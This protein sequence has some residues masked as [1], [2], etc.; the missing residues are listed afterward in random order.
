MADKVTTPWQSRIKSAN[1][2]YAKWEDKYKCKD[3]EKYYQGF[4]WVG[5][6]ELP[7][8]YVLNMVYS[9][10][11]IK[12]ASYSFQDI[13]FHVSPRPSRADWNLDLAIQSAQAKEDV[14]NTIVGNPNGR[15]CAELE[16]AIKDSFLRFGVIE[17]GYSADWIDNPNAGKPLYVGD[18]DI[19]K[20]T[21]EPVIERQPD[22]IPVN[23]LIY[24]KRIPASRFRVGGIEG[25]YLD[26][27]NWCGYYDFYYAEDIK[28]SPVLQNTDVIDTVS[29]RT[30]EFDS[31]TEFDDLLKKGDLI[32]IWKIWDNR[33]KKLLLY[34]PANDLIY[35]EKPFRR[36]PIFSLRWCT[37]H[38]GW[39]PIPPV[40][41]WISPQ[42][43]VN[44]SRQQMRSYRRR[45]NR[46]FQYVENTVEQGELDKFEEAKDGAIIKVQKQ[47][48]I[49]PIQDA[50]LNQVV[51]QA[52]IIGKDDFVMV[53]GT[54]SEAMGQGDRITAT[55]SMEIARRFGVRESRE[56]IKVLDWIAKIGREA[57]MTAQEKLIGGIWAKAT[58]DPGEGLMSEMNTNPMWNYII[59]QDLN[60]GVDYDIDLQVTTMSPI[61]N[62][63]EKQKFIEFMTILNSFPMI[64]LSPLLI[65]EAAYRVGYRNERVIKEMQNAS[66]LQSLGQ[67]AGQIP[68]NTPG[69]KISQENMAQQTP[70]D[71]EQIRNQI[72]NQVLRTQ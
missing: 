46:Q 54:S 16:A 56:Q 72:Q 2:Y 63:A 7:G 37:D 58:Q 69:D 14:L 8:A 44:E 48:A 66:I 65:R 70:P 4:H 12:L 49:T 9:T 5:D 31:S 68:Q 19:N 17:T 32:K 6:D 62:Q 60:D 10:I 25:R 24:F 42:D 20:E 33:S 21:Q 67:M 55:Q 22:K 38:L 18:E 34:D 51:P 28:S 30:V 57:L 47:D 59:S 27:S 61:E 53:S 64:A 71:M 39:Y 36:L 26:Q 13:R 40:F 11:E 15:F 43:E 35:Y 50:P 1:E 45:F 3:L 29:H 52:M 41:N 23:E